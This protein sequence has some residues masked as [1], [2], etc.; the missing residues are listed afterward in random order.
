MCIFARLMP[1]THT[2]VYHM[3]I[4]KKRENDCLTINTFRNSSKAHKTIIFCYQ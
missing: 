1:Y 2:P 3:Y 4:H